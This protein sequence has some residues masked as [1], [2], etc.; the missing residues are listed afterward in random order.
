MF[1]LW[2]KGMETN[3]KCWSFEKKQN[4]L[5]SKGS[6]SM[7]MPLNIQW[8][9]LSSLTHSNRLKDYSKWKEIAEPTH[10][11][12]CWQKSSASRSRVTSRWALKLLQSREFH[13]WSAEVEK[14]K[15]ENL[16]KRITLRISGRNDKF[17]EKEKKKKRRFSRQFQHFQ[18]Y[19][20]GHED[21]VDG[22]IGDFVVLLKLFHVGHEPCGRL[23]VQLD[24]GLQP[25]RHAVLRI[26][27]GPSNW[28]PWMLKKF[29]FDKRKRKENG[30]TESN[31]PIA[32]SQKKN[33]N[34]N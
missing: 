32:T 27:H 18:A 26:P 7:R 23:P 14:S 12:K 11:E 34:S 6:I 16:W 10:P 2:K 4:I 29:C 30:S 33:S 25:G 31:H 17:R 8:K 15:N 5:W 20:E 19:L 9:F 21:S 28:Q 3:E 24:D 13:E 22:G 1:E